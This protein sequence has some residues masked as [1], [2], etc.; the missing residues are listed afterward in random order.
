MDQRIH[1]ITFI[2]IGLLLTG[3]GL[4]SLLFPAPARAAEA[5][6]IQAAWIAGLAG[7]GLLL[8]RRNQRR[9]VVQGG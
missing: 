1:K 7:L 5:L 9:L 6:L 2:L 4:S 8:W 3:F